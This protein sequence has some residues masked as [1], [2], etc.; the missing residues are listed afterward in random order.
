VTLVDPVGAG[1]AFN[2]GFI[3]ARDRDYPLHQ[4]AAIG[5]WAAGQVVAHPGDW[6]G[7]PTA[8]EFDAWIKSER[9]I[10]R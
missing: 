10:D 9:Q 3:F 8:E 2:A 6:E 1:D 7:L 4:C 5:N